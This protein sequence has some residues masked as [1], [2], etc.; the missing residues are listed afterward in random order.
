MKA[1]LSRS[2]AGS[3]FERTLLQEGSACF[4]LFYLAV[5]RL[6]IKLNGFIIGAYIC[7]VQLLNPGLASNE[8]RGG[9]ATVCQMLALA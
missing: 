8:K 4:P 7:F 2:Y 1:A 9:T 5:F 3:H 6:S